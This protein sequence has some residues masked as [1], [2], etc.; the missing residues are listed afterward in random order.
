MSD[1]QVSTVTIYWSSPNGER[2]GKKT[3][4][5]APERLLKQARNYERRL[6]NLGFYTSV[7]ASREVL[8]HE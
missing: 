4:S 8:C 2:D 1:E 3:L 6:L 7:E 5:G